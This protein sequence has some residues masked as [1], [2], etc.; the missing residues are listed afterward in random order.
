MQE[1]D[2]IA[3]VIC[4]QRMVA[5]EMAEYVRKKAVLKHET[6]L[7][8][9]KFDKRNRPK[10]KILTV[11]FEKLTYDIEGFQVS[12]PDTSPQSHRR[13][14][15]R[16]FQSQSKKSKKGRGGIFNIFSNVLQIG[17]TRDRLKSLINISGSQTNIQSTKAIDSSNK[18][19]SVSGL[20]SSNFIV[21]ANSRRSSV[22]NKSI[23]LDKSGQNESGYKSPI[24]ERSNSIN[25]SKDVPSNA[26][27]VL[28]LRKSVTVIESKIIDDQGK[29]SLSKKG[30]SQLTDYFLSKSQEPPKKPRMF[31]TD[32]NEQREIILPKRKFKHVCFA[33]A[34]PSLE[35]DEQEDEGRFKHESPDYDIFTIKAA[36][37]SAYMKDNDMAGMLDDCLLGTFN[38]RR[39][40]DARAK[41]SDDGLVA[42]DNINKRYMEF[43]I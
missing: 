8:E 39:G 13:S 2:E 21:R 34:I 20:K 3:D 38:V 31:F 26:M 29:Q 37:M 12:K 18:V 7:S 40:S 17:N 22:E 27:A 41:A 43:D 42:K 30:K 6:K 28:S 1:E 19:D 32:E 33:S 25:K 36:P 10:Q 14:S 9:S 5:T 23:N 15:N 11:N 16:S 4:G 24:L 35:A